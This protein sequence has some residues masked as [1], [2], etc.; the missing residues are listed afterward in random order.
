[1]YVP[2]FRYHR[3]ARVEEACRLLEANDGAAALA[4]GTDLLVDLKRGTRRAR[5]IVSLTGSA[6]DG[7]VR[8]EKELGSHPS[9]VFSGAAISELADFGALYENARAMR[10]LPLDPRQLAVMILSALLPFLPLVLLVMPAREVLQALREL[11]L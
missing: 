7:A 1:M 8:L 2:D 10:P 4:G 6:Y 9:D 3:P 11:V 5:E